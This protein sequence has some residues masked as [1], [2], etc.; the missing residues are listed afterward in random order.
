[1]IRLYTAITPPCSKTDAP[2]NLKCPSSPP[3]VLTATLSAVYVTIC[4]CSA[5]EVHVN[6]GGG[7]GASSRPWVNTFPSKF[8][9]VFWN[10][11]IACSDVLIT[12]SHLEVKADIKYLKS[13]SV[14]C[15]VLTVPQLP[16][17]SAPDRYFYYFKAEKRLSV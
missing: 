12:L 8:Y 7:G 4:K 5:K 13:N 1:M 2:L 17:S 9:V 6:L 15:C 14:R 11:R 16:H 10:P 3:L